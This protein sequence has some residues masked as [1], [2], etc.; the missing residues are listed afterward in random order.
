MPYVQGLGQSVKNIC[1][2]HG[3]QTYSKGN[4]TLKSIVVTPKDKDQIQ[5]KWYNTVIK[6]Q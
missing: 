4:R 3:I 6:V 1:G 2:K 5:H